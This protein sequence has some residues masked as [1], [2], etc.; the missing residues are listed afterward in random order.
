MTK[1]IMVEATL[2]VFQDEAAITIYLRD[3][4]HYVNVQK[5]CQ[6]KIQEEIKAEAEEEI[7]TT[8]A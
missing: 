4:T 2:N 6:Q 3:V 7:V 1:H 5:F 8:L